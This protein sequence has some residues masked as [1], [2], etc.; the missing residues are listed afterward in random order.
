M[1][2][3]WYWL[4]WLRVL[5][6]GTIFLFHSSRPFDI[7]APWHVMNST[8][9]LG[10]TLFDSFISGWIMP[11]FFVISG[12]AVYSSLARRS[13]SEF[14]RDRLE[15]L[16]IPFIFGLLFVLPVNVYYDA[17][18]HGYFVGDFVSFY[19]GPYFTKAFPF[20][21][22]FSPTY[23][24][25]SNQGVYLWYLFWLFIFSI[26]TVHFFKW[27]V[28]EGNLNKFSKLHAVCNRRGGILLLAVPVILVNI[29][30]VPP[31]FVFPSGYGGWKLPTYL[32]LFITAYVIATNPRFEEAIEKNRLPTLLLG[33]LTSLLILAVTAV[34]VGKP[35]G[36]GSGSG[37][38][39]YYVVVSTVWALNGWCWVTAIIGFGR[40]HLSFNHKYLKVSNELV[41]P[42]YILHQSV[43]VAVAFYVVSLDL[44]VIEK[45]LLV[46]LASFPII[47]V[48]IYPIS[49]INVLRFL[50][51]MRMK[52]RSR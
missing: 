49:K 2:E 37:I 12:I 43:I 28:R 32:V 33:I 13:A 40:K 36:S 8:W 25:D 19:L 46:L 26:V 22:N 48:L 3:R 17:V 10:F 24:A 16:I 6:M 21:V 31:F 23:F 50:F 15:R 5:A 1:P 7:S 41:L 9:D 44:I 4:D 47:A 51:G 29:A 30:A 27:L 18:F 35:T 20:S 45:Y 38:D 52:N 11:L 34:T 14:A 42:F 39:A